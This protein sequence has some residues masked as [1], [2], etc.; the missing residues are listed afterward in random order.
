M[1]ISLPLV[2]R[3]LV[4][5]GAL[6]HL[7]SLFLVY[8][9]I[10]ELPRPNMRRAWLVMGF[11][12]LF[13][14][15]SYLAFLFWPGSGNAP[16]ENVELLAPFILFFGAIFV[17]LTNLLALK[18]TL[19]IKR[20]CALERENITDPLL[21]I[22]N[23]RHLEVLLRQE[24]LLCRREALPLS[25]LLI[26]IDHFKEIND[27][28]GHLAGDKALIGLVRVIKGQLRQTDQLARYGGEEIMVMLPHTPEAAAL[29]LA[30]KLCRT[31]AAKVM[32]P[33]SH[34]EEGQWPDIY[35]TVSIGVAGLAKEINSEKELFA[36]ADQALYRAKQ[37]GRNRCAAAVESR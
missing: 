10:K 14:F 23:R 15:V 9:L 24:F 7:A 34:N 31:I 17:L 30:E 13:F 5:L 37:A 20:V 33:A 1:S 26:D 6:L 27:S 32:A 11:F 28:Y 8:R 4:L 2:L 25:L 18:T 29:K 12:I 21:G 22:F 36:R 35:L 3:S 16:P 19:D